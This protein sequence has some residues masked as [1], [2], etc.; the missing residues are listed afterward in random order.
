MPD[1][2]LKEWIALLKD[3]L[4]GLAAIVTIFVGVYGVRAWKR[5]LVGKE[6]Y[7]A[8]RKLV[9]ESHLVCRAARTL[10]QPLWAYDKRQFTDEEI[11]HTTESERWRL[12]EAEGYKAKIEKFA[13]ELKRYESAKLDLRVL[14][15]SKIY[16]GF[17]PF[18]RSL[19]ESI[20]RVNAYLDLL[21]DFSNTYFPD[22]P[23]IIE[24]QRQ[25]YPSD[26]LDDDL[27]QNLADSREEGEVLL[28]S[29]LHRK[30]IYG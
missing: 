23:Q 10:R 13:E 30:S 6:V 11:E 17:L 8:A 22:S 3:A 15:G 24:A 28:L 16:E 18:G 14:V 27:S 2:E 19:A 29:H 7:A 9:K 1:P 4:L 20:E 12:S 5:D 25:L 26:N 21:Q